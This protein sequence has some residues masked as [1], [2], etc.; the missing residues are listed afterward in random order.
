M[1]T[2]GDWLAIGAP[3]DT[4]QSPR[5]HGAVYLYKRD[6]KGTWSLQ[7]RLANPHPGLGC[8]FGHEVALCGSQ[9]VVGS[10][11]HPKALKGMGAVD[12]YELHVPTGRWRPTGMESPLLETT[13]LG[14]KVL[15]CKGR[16]LAIESNSGFS[17]GSPAG[18][19]HLYTPSD[20]TPGPGHMELT[21]LDNISFSTDVAMVNANE[22][23]SCL[24]ISGR[25]AN[26]TAPALLHVAHK[27]GRWNTQPLAEPSTDNGVPPA[28]AFQSIAATDSL[29]V[30]GSPKWNH[31]T[32]SV[33][34]L[35]RD[36]A[37]GF[38]HDTFLHPEQAQGSGEFGK[39]VAVSGSWVAVGA[40]HGVV[41]DAHRGAVSLFHEQGGGAGR[42][43]R[44]LYIPATSRGGAAGFG[45]SLA[46]TPQMMAV[47][48]PNSGMAEAMDPADMDTAT[49]AVFIY[50][51]SEPLP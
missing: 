18:K 50:E 24:G 41:A 27:D 36:A 15:A 33:W 6:D 2:R 23:I 43:D 5:N 21:S 45:Y 9:L 42:W 39:S 8:R 31:L 49:G 26:P 34:I 3:N 17:T 44:R 48:A 29:V 19:V 25:A 14:V 20:T 10:P 16:F 7:Q 37:G 30:A 40:D 4:S 32:G 28:D 38:A 22:F 51:F 13:A 12:I 1:S 46:L 11:R 35:R 47:G